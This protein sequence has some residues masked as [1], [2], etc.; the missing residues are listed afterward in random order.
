MFRLKHISQAALALCAGGLALSAAAQ[1]QQTGQQKLDRVEVTGSRIKRVDAETPSPVQVISREQIERSGATTLT[2]V[3]KSVP[4]NNSGSFDENAVASFTPGAGGVS[5]RGLGAGATLVLINGRRVAP[6]GFASGGQTTFVDVNSIPLDVIERIETLLDGASAIY[7]S[8]AIAGVVN[9][10]LRKDFAGFTASGSFGTSSYH[11]ANSNRVGLTFGTGSLASDRYNI[12]GSYSHQGRD[13]V[14][15]SDRPNTATADF[16]RF[17]LADLRS[18]YAYPGNLYNQGNSAFIGPMPGCTPVADGSALNGRCVYEGTAHQD[19]IADT[20]RDSLFVAGTVDLGNSFEL[21]GDASISRSK[22]L[23][24]SP[25]Y[26]SSTYFST[27]TLGA[28]VIVLP[29]GHPQNPTSNPVGLRYRFMDVPHN[30]QVESTTQRYV[31]GGRGNLAGWDAE[32]AL[33][34]SKSDTEVITTGL[35][36]DSV[37]LNEVLD[38]ATGMARP[39]FIFGNPAANDPGL[40]SRL[41]PTLKD[42]GTTSTT[43]WDVRGSRELMNLPGGPMGLAVGFETRKEKFTSTPDP[44]TAANELSV[45]GASSSDGSRT[46][47]ALYAEVSLPVFKS[48]EASLA[49]R[50]DRY[51]DFGSATTPKVGMKWKV[52]PNLALRGTYAHGFRAPSL[53]ETSQ[54]PTR[55]FYTGIR[56]PQLCPDPVN[57]PN[58]NCNLSLEAVSGS[59][60]NLQPEKSRSLTAGIVLDVTD[61]ISVSV[62]GYRIKRRNEISSIDPDYL[63]ANESRYPGYVVRDPVTGE[64]QQLNLQY[65]NLGSTRVWG[66]D[67]EVKSRLSLNEFGKVGFQIAYNKLPRYLVSNVA[68]APEVDYAG[69]WLQPKERYK[70]GISWDYGAWA[71]SLT[72]SYVGGYLRAFTPSDLSCPYSTSRPERCKVSSWMT[73]DVFIGYKGFK[74]LDLGL[75]INNIDNRQAPLDERRANRYTLFNSTYHNQLGRYFTL[76]AKYTF[77]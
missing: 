12:F 76:G 11:D 8:D 54:S 45:L 46:V 7:G 55:S 20:Q 42:K 33:M 40:M 28:P 48:F 51:S 63:L 71:A 77:W 66:Y 38:P 27:G 44:I 32:S 35:L 19:V 59:N 21:F 64:I 34:V 10:I 16:R 14:K 25:S 5:L 26:S 3:L 24:E 13:A 53:T 29:V 60:P 4:A 2:E 17:G 36:R 52:L 37:L 61:D 57:D 74:N 49:A 62:D 41:Y 43:S 18:T 15:A 47:N 73:S 58:A 39:T 1:Q 50:M 70:I 22:Y 30:T 75:T 56:D 31:V 6:F 67:V 65:T 23:Q 69:T 68:G 72:T 9:I